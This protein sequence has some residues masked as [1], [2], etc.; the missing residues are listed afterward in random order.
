MKAGKTVAKK[1]VRKVAPRNQVLY[2]K[3]VCW[4]GY[5]IPVPLSAQWMAWDGEGDLYS[6]DKKPVW[7]EET[8]R[9]VPAYML[10]ATRM[11]MEVDVQPPRPG[12]PETQLWWIG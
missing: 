6:Y 9:W 10:G 7:N 11:T 8:G 2:H 5:S 3:V 12:P 1:R 4:D